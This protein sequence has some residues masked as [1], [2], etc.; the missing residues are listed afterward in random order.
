M[1]NEVTV[2]SEDSV[3]SYDKARSLDMTDD[4]HLLAKE[5]KLPSGI[6]DVEFLGVEIAPVYKFMGTF[7]TAKKPCSGPAYCG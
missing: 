3:G 1:Q 4:M 6:G 2:N 5:N 7:I